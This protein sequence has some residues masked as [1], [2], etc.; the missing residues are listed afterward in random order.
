MS[1]ATLSTHVLDTALGQPAAGVRVSLLSEA[2]AP[3][4]QARTGDDGRIADLVPGGIEPG[5]YR[6]VFELEGYFAD[7]PHL[8]NAVSLELEIVEARHHHVPLLIGPYAC[9]AYR[10]S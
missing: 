9:S 8:F 7:R 3:Q 6:L 10:G 2:G 5:A 4:G 1:R